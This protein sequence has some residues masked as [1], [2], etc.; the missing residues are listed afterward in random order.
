MP[1]RL[2]RVVQGVNLSFLL[3]P[4]VDIVVGMIFDHALGDVLVRPA[5]QMGADRAPA[6]ELKWIRTGKLDRPADPPATAGGG[7]ERVLTVTVVAEHADVLGKRTC[8]RGLSHRFHKEFF[9]RGQSRFARSRLLR[10]FEELVAMIECKRENFI[11]RRSWRRHPVQSAERHILIRP[12]N[13]LGVGEKV[14]ELHSGRHRGCTSVARDDQRTTGVGIAAAGIVILAAHPARQEACGKRVARAEHVQHR[15]FDAAAI[16]GVIE[17]ARN[18]AVD[19]RAPHRAALD[20]QHGGGK[21]AH[22]AQR[23]HDVGA[24]AGDV[25]LLDGAHDEID[26]GQNAL[27]M[28]AHRV[29]ANVSR[30]TVTAL[31]QAPE[32]RPIIDVEDSPHV[33]LARAIEREIA[34]AVDVLGRKMGTG[35]QKRFASRDERLLDIGFGNGHVGAVFA[36]KDQRERVLVLDA[37]HDCASQTRRVGADMADVATFAIVSTRNLPRPSSPVREIN[38]AFNP[39]LA[40]PNAV[41]AEEPPRYFA[42]LVTSSSRAPICCA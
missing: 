3:Q 27:Q 26:L 13:R 2:D 42:K 12:R 34:D 24:A 15:D 22:R 36:H 37:Q 39:S 11:A 5:Q 1:A 40:Q 8:L 35:D 38:A 19:D 32:H 4:I 21:R 16:E 41:L 31:G 7:V 14:I 17:R 28:R 9:E 29:G 33:V 20:Q 25:E 6:V 10:Q 23:L 30:F 18:R